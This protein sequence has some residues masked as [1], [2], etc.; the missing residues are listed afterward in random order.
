MSY[1]LQQSVSYAL[2]FIQYSPL[3]VGTGN[4]PA[5]ST[6]NEIQNTITNQPFTWPWNRNENKTLTTVI[7]QQ[8][9]TLNLTDFS[10]LEKVTLTDPTNGETWIVKDVYNN[11]AQGLGTTI[12]TKYQR[13]NSVAVQSVTYGTSVVLRF[14][15]IPDKAYAVSVIYQ[16]LVIPITSLAN[17]WSIP[18][19]YL[20]IYNNLF[21]GEAMAIVDDARANVYR[22]RGV[23]ALLSK[24]EGLSEMQR[25]EFLA[26]YW[27]RDNQQLA[28]Q[29]RTQ[30]A[31]QARGV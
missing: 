10:F 27:A 29:L 12:A 3:N 1:T 19:Q 25:N 21:V 15:G 11:R 13:P 16:K 30:Q 24:A 6:A 17:N 8:D 22:Q 28:A 23:A 14:M 4:E 20:D 2:T 5:I 7:G 9:Y 26:Q 31:A 18:D